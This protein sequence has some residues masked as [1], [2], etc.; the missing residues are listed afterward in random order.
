MPI[1]LINL[2]LFEYFKLKYS[3]KI[4]WI[5]YTATYSYTVAKSVKQARKGYNSCYRHR[6]ELLQELFQEFLQDHLVLLLLC[7]TS[8]RPRWAVA[9]SAARQRPAARDKDYQYHHRT[10]NYIY[11][12]IGESN[13]NIKQCN[14]L[15]VLSLYTQPFQFE[16]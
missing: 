3:N 9:T 12:R 5:P 14:I 15:S 11:N 16:P 8:T 4:Q 1:E 10:R 13:C 2:I 7:Y 6:Q